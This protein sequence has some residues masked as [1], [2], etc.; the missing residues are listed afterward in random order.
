MSKPPKPPNQCQAPV[1]VPGPG[2]RERAQK[3]IKKM[4]VRRQP[5]D[6]QEQPTPHTEPTNPAELIAANNTTITTTR[7]S[8]STTTTTLAAA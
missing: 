8:S 1:Y 3:L 6:T 5:N 4:E 2:Q 7:S